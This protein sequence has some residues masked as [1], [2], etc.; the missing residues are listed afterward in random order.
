MD[1][2]DPIITLPTELIVEI[3]WSLSYSDLFNYFTT[4]KKAFKFSDEEQFLTSL[5]QKRYRCSIVGLSWSDFAYLETIFIRSRTV[6]IHE[7]RTLSDNSAMHD[8]WLMARAVSGHLVGMSGFSEELLILIIEVCDLGIVELFDRLIG[9]LIE[10]NY[11]L[12]QSELEG[13]LPMANLP[14]RTRQFLSDSMELI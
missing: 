9:S 7:P 14:P 3:V 10:D 2:T 11:L 8:Q 6:I 12:T 1:C 4:H 5:V 13:Y